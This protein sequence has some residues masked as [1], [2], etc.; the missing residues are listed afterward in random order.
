MDASSTVLT[1]RL[2]QE[3]MGR[4]HATGGPRSWEVGGLY[5]D[6]LAAF[7]HLARTPIRRLAGPCGEVR[8]CPVEKLIVERVLISKYPGDFPPALACAKKLLAAALL[9]EVETHWAEVQRLAEDPAYQ[10][11][12]DVK[13]LVHEQAKALQVR[14]PYHPDE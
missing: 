5:V 12:N 1:A 6:V 7:E 14:S 13:E 8:I 10:N 11:W 3:L 2:R 4:L 9:T